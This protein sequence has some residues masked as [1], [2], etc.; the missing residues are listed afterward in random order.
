MI[1]DR[2]LEDILAQDYG[3]AI[4]AS[5]DLDDIEEDVYTN[6]LRGAMNRIDESYLNR[7][8]SLV[9]E[10]LWDKI[11]GSLGGS[12][13][14]NMNDDPIQRKIAQTRGETE[15]LPGSFRHKAQED[16][17]AIEAQR[18]KREKLYGEAPTAHDKVSATIKKGL[19]KLEAQKRRA[20]A[21]KAR[22]K[23]AL[24]NKKKTKKEQEEEDARK[25]AEKYSDERS[26]TETSLRKY[27]ETLRG[28][29]GKEA[30]YEGGEEE[31]QDLANTLVNKI[32]TKAESLGGTS[33][34][35]IARTVVAL[36]LRRFKD[37]AGLDWL[38]KN[39][40]SYIDLA[41]EELKKQK[42]K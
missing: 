29:I 25:R 14:R 41:E 16:I 5:E 19:N 15:R 4:D 6:L 23:L 1:E 21:I 3:L 2:L 13:S 7:I 26:A 35:P 24:A 36:E 34:Y 8:D 32:Y 30:P 11:K 9:N 28:P 12:G 39:F 27:A 20:L 40:D 42:L 10:G 18:A 33:N 38:P 37:E 22:Q 17:G 31:R